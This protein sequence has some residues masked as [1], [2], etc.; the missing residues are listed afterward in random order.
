MV[1]LTAWPTAP[2]KV[3]GQGIQRRVIAM[4]AHGQARRP[5]STA[6]RGQKSRRVL[7]A[8]R[9]RRRS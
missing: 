9:S 1:L 3:R 8:R 4:V 6:R 7:R 5:E 2:H